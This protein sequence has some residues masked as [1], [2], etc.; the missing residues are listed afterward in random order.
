[1]VTSDTAHHRRAALS[2]RVAR[3]GPAAAIPRTALKRVAARSTLRAHRFPGSATE[4]HT[5]IGETSGM[6]TLPSPI[7]RWKEFYTDKGIQVT[8]ELHKNSWKS[9]VVLGGGNQLLFVA[10]SKA[11][12]SLYKRRIPAKSRQLPPKATD[13]NRKPLA[14]HSS[15]TNQRPGSRQRPRTDERS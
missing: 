8:D 13:S 3:P 11:T 15:T 10:P 9:F 2:S 4:S 7:L 12:H 14:S 5:N 6:Q 1:M